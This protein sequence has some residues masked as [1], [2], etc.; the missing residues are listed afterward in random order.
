MSAWSIPWG[1][2][3]FWCQRFRRRRGGEN[4]PS[5]AWLQA[6]ASENPLIQGTWSTA[7]SSRTAEEMNFQICS[8]LRRFFKRSMSRVRYKRQSLVILTCIIFT[9]VIILLHFVLLPAVSGAYNDDCYLSETKLNE[10]RH[11]ILTSAE[12]MEKYNMTYWL[13]FGKSCLIIFC[14]N[15]I[16]YTDNYTKPSKWS[17]L[18]TLLCIYNI[19]LRLLADTRFET[20]LKIY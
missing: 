1:S 9:T 5:T 2:E 3:V 4:L 7:W 6:T 12:L 17:N 20:Q 8:C 16:I 15:R 14:D 11:L 10:L 18:M 13:D 19:C